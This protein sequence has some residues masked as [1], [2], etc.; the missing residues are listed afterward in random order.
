MS[1]STKPTIELKQYGK[2]AERVI[3]I[4]SE[5]NHIASFPSTR[6]PRPYFEPH[7]AKINEFTWLLIKSI[8]ILVTLRGFN[9]TLLNKASVD[10]QF[11]QIHQATQSAILVSDYAITQIDITISRYYDEPGRG[12]IDGPLTL[13]Q[14]LRALVP[15]F[16][17]LGAKVDLEMTIQIQL[18]ELRVKFGHQTADA[19]KKSL[20]HMNCL[21]EQIANVRAAT[22]D[23]EMMNES[24]KRE[25]MGE[26]LRILG[27]TVLTSSGRRHVIDEKRED[28]KAL[29]SEIKKVP[30]KI[31]EMLES[32][33]EVDDT[34]SDIF[35]EASEIEVEHESPDIKFAELDRQLET[36]RTNLEWMREFVNRKDE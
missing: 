4:L 13:Y 29:A 20:V 27:R 25:N 17:N 11:K 19:W 28:D 1:A 33:P 36:I 12:T 3:V 16:S 8:P 23:S 32:I 35:F 10:P 21:K 26:V 22:Y 7:L 15:L 6:K 9:N 14:F 31:K 18:Y 34:G 24:E 2:Q 30:D 5:I